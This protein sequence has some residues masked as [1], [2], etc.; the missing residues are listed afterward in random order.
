MRVPGE[1]VLTGAGCLGLSAGQ[2]WVALALL[3]SGATPAAP[4]GAL[5]GLEDCLRWN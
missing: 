4:E 5:V 3:P 2:W 1:N